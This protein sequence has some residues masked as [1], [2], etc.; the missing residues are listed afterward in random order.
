M[1]S[2]GSWV[3]PGKFQNFKTDHV[4]AYLSWKLIA[5]RLSV[6]LSVCPSVRP[7]VNFS[8]FRPL[9]KN[10][11]ANCNQTRHKASLGKGDSSFQMKGPTLLQG[12]IIRLQNH[13]TE[14]NQIWLKSSLGEGDSSL[15]K[16]RACLDLF[17][18]KIIMKKQKYL[19]KFLKSSSSEPLGQF[20]PNLAQIICGWKELKFV[21]MKGPVL[22]QGEIITNSEHTL[23]NLKNLLQNLWV[24]LNKIW[25]KSSLA[26][27]DSC[28]GPKGI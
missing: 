9:L 8:Y 1:K 10:H 18:E 27:G 13:W 21:Q 22:F 15:F 24:N 14:F 3:P 23:T 25:H 28:Q 2:I 6:W 5:R 11:W 12:K 26:K 4:L 16:L 19:D 17:Q 20:Q 7:S